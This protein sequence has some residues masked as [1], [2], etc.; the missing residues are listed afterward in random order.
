M[1]DK[2]RIEILVQLQDAFIPEEK[3]ESRLTTEVL[4]IDNH[5]VA[6]V[7]EIKDPPLEEQLYAKYPDAIAIKEMIM[8][9]SGNNEKPVKEAGTRLRKKFVGAFEDPEMI[10][11]LAAVCRD[12]ETKYYSTTDDIRKQLLLYRFVADVDKI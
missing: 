6:R 2:D 1:K 5:N 11:K 9:L 10:I 3:R 7:T 4:R 8:I 12:A